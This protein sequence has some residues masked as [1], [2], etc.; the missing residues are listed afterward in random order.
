GN[1]LEKA[2]IKAV[3]RRLCPT[4]SAVTRCASALSAVACSAVDAGKACIQASI[5]GYSSGA[6][7]TRILRVLRVRHPQFPASRA[8]LPTRSCPLLWAEAPS[9]AS[10]GLWGHVV[11]LEGSTGP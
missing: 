8:L 10:S 5:N 7:G 4:S 6:E 11:N 9:P 3:G 2:R 1:V